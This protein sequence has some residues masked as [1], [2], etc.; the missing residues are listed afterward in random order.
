MT[1]TDP[2]QPGRTRPGGR[3]ALVRIAVLAA[4]FEVL[5]ERGYERTELPEIARRAG[6]HPTTVYRRWGTKSR[7]IGEALL[8]RSR[9]LS[10]TPDTGALRT[11]LERLLLDGA[12]L[13]RTPA[14][15]ALFEVLISDSAD[16]SPELK[17]ARDRFWDA[18]LEEARGIVE[19]AVARSELPAGTDPV[20]LIDLVIGPALLR[21]MLMG[22]ELGPEDV[23]RIV[24]RA[25][26]AVGPEHPS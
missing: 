6:V 3:S 13:V 18:H 2:G 11:D 26:V 10:P 21:L 23:S 9:P 14:V 16:S 24:A 5:A 17:A 1:T 15:R 4:T 25:I 7:L 8:E 12:T 19:R 20:D 22:Q